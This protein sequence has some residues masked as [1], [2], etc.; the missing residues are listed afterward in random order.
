V[1]PIADRKIGPGVA[2][3]VAGDHGERPVHDRKVFPEEYRLPRDRIAT[4]EARQQKP[5][6]EGPHLIP[7]ERRNG[8][9]L[10]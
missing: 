7:R 1:I 3:E 5:T 6:T 8:L 4:E 9:F 2:V 10:S